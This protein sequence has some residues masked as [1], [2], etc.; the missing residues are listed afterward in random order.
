MLGPG[1]GTIRRCDLVGVGVALLEEMC[2]SGG[3]LGEVPPTCLD[4]SLLQFAF[5][6]RYRTLNSSNH[7]CLDAAIFSTMMIMD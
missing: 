2:H 1:S 4:G 5:G 3:G 7:T 6:T